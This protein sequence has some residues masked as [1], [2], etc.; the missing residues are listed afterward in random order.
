M[1]DHNL[2]FVRYWS[3][4]FIRQ[5]GR[6]NRQQTDRQI[7]KAF[8]SVS[9]SVNKFVNVTGTKS[10]YDGDLLY[11]S[12]R[13]SNLY[14]GHTARA[15]KRQ[16]HKCGKCSLAF[17]PGDNVELHHIDGNH[18]NWKTNNLVALHRECHQGQKIHS[19]T[20]QQ[21]VHPKFS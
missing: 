18:H 15:L 4:K 21:R 1:N 17:L 9:W 10:P 16:E 20:R 2:W 6:F 3:W 19:L 5:Q 13:N 8:P 12:R 7:D 11:W 14:S